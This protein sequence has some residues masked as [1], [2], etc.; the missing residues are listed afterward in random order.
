M[1]DGKVRLRLNKRVFVKDLEFL[2]ADVR[3]E[4]CTKMFQN[5]LSIRIESRALVSTGM[6]DRMK[7][8]MIEWCDENCNGY[9]QFID[10]E[11]RIMFEDNAD[12]VAFK[13]AFEDMKIV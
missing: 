6:A 12:L 11:R 10:N 7:M 4:L 13:L 2:P 9:Y 1:S 5:Q 3:D 8:K